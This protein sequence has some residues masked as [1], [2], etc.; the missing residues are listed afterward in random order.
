MPNQDGTGPNRQNRCQNSRSNNFF[1]S[2]KESFR[3]K[4]QQNG[5][6][7]AGEASGL[8]QRKNSQNNS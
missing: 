5:R 6:C 4:G 2:V 7:C 3:G 1:A 8:R